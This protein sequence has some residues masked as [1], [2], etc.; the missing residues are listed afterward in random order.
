MTKPIVCFA[1]LACA[2]G[3][4]AADWRMD[5]FNPMTNELA[6]DHGARVDDQ[7]YVHLQA[8]NR[9]WAQ[10]DRYDTAHLYTF[11]AN[12]QAPWMWGL[13]LARDG[14][15]CG[16]AARGGQRLDCLSVDDG[17]GNRQPRLEMRRSG[18]GSPAWQ[19][20]LPGDVAVRG[21]AI[22]GAGG[23][24][25][26][27]TRDAAWQPSI[28]TM[29]FAADG[30]DAGQSSTPACPGFGQ[31]I[32][33]SRFH[34]PTLDGGPVV[35]ARACAGDFGDR[36]L[37]VDVFD[38]TLAQWSPR[39][40]RWLPPGESV[41]RIEIGADGRVYAVL[42]HDGAPYDLIAT[43]ATLGH[44]RPV[45]LPT[46]LGLPPQ[47]LL[48]DAQRLV[49]I[50]DDADPIWPTP[51]SAFWYDL[52]NG[53]PYWLTIGTYPSLAGFEVRARALSADG[54]LLLLGD[55]ATQPLPSEQ[56]RF[57]GRSGDA[58][59][60]AALPLETYETRVGRGYLL[61]APGGAAIV[62]RTLRAD[63]GDAIE[64]GVRVNQYDL[65][66]AP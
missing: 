52:D 32:E 66:P 4:H 50:P 17:G 43:D 59:I 28:V 19:A 58:D 64:T 26:V 22:D 45:A 21:L 53:G 31:H 8:F 33:R 30:T 23:A 41:E 12:G 16:L 49:V 2:F 14:T 9:P 65:P 6:D 42:A 35:L 29:R 40:S 36:T 54:R 38:T 34:M 5:I 18:G 27:A 62:A 47:A 1:L 11:D 24:L 3:A 39:A 57:A 60:L 15:S 37:S 46:P 7:G 44:W 10:A 55:D 13:T 56:L 48:A 51:H 25:V 63:L 61:A 20:P